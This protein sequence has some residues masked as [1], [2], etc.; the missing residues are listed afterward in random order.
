[1]HIF[2]VYNDLTYTI[3]LEP[4]SLAIDLQLAM[5][6]HICLPPTEQYWSIDGV[7]CLPTSPATPLESLGLGN[8]KHMVLSRTPAGTQ[9]VPIDA[10]WTNLGIL[11]FAELSANREERTVERMEASPS[12]LTPCED[13]PFKSTAYMVGLAC[14]LGLELEQITSLGAPHLPSTLPEEN[15]ELDHWPSRRENLISRLRNLIRRVEALFQRL[16]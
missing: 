12:Q 5:W 4:S 2:V 3:S 8:G 7:R 11:R 13:T 1:M 16:A 6:K 9:R 15:L 10:F 14:R